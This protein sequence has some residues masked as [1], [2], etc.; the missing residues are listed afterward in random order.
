MLLQA[1]LM[2]KSISHQV[3]S[4]HRLVQAAVIRRIPSFERAK[5]LDAAIE[6]LA[7]ILVDMWS[8]DTNYELKTWTKQVWIQ[9]E[10]CLPHIT[11]L[12][13]QMKMHEI[14][15]KRRQKLGE[16]LISCVG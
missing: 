5:Y 3:L 4:V 16:L 10:R 15:T 12:V 11:N 2:D 9:H 14:Q 8:Q 13:K 1:A 7:P 6:L